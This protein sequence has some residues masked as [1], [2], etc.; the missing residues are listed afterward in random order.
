MTGALN[1][2]KLILMRKLVEEI[3]SQMVKAPQGSI[4]LRDDRI[5]RKWSVK[6][7]EFYISPYLVTQE[8]YKIITGLNPAGFSSQKC[9]VENVSWLDAVKFCNKLSEI[10]GLAPS[11]K[12]VEGEI[13]AEF[14]QGNS[15]FCLPTEAQWEYACRAGTDTIRYE[16]KLDDIAWYE[17]NSQGSTS[18]VGLKKPNAWGLFDM[19]GNTWEWCSDVYDPEQYGAYRIFRGGGWADKDRGVL[20]TNRRRGHPTF[21]IDDLG[22]RLARHK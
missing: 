13:G 15:G 9:P 22:F 5:N 11:Y 16:E 7:N 21:K 3:F 20:A 4:M 1:I 19:L 2:V 12:L 10:K 17:S 8:S 14:I 18:P 6:L